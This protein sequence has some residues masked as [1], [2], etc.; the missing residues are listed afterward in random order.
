[1]SGSTAA[2][3][4]LIALLAAIAGCSAVGSST[5]PPTAAGL[6]L[7][8]PAATDHPPTG[9]DESKMLALGPAATGNATLALVARN[10]LAETDAPSSP[11]DDLPRSP[12]L[13]NGLHNPMPG[14]V[15][16]GYRGDTGLD[17]A[18][19]RQPVYAIAAGTLDYSEPGH[20]LWT[21]PGDT[22]HTVRLRLD[23]PIAYRGRHITHAWYAHLS[24]LRYR[25]PE[26]ADEPIHVAA[27][28]QLGISGVANGSPHLHLGL[29]LDDVVSQRWGS[30]LLEDQI[31]EV[32]GGYGHRKRLPRTP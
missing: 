16:A 13:P 23:E 21:G 31:R 32:L 5:L 22:D 27:G 14:G 29:L 12:P 1:M 25:Q 9:R 2:P 6:G 20:T 28:E 18:G 24:E 17:L 7:P 19:N 11:A 30:Y 8:E 15:M 10:D 3:L 26:G 4:R